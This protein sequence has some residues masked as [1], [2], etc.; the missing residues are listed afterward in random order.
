[1]THILDD[2]PTEPEIIECPICYE[3]FNKF[4]IDGC[5]SCPNVWCASCFVNSLIANRGHTPCPF[6]RDPTGSQL[7]YM[8]MY[9]LHSDCLK[10]VHYFNL[11]R[12]E[13]MDKIFAI[14]WGE[15][16]YYR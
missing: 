12:K 15:D 14:E 2:E 13:W 6:C 9:E 5:G 8:N 16:M 3:K 7:K 11:D 1:M 4:S 10:F